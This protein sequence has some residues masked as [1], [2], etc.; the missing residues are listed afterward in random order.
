MAVLVPIF[1]PSEVFGTM[2]LLLT[3]LVDVDID[4]TLSVFAGLVGPE[5]GTD[6]HGWKWFGGLE[7]D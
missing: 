4:V 5:K 2:V 6:G 1:F 3:A 7:I